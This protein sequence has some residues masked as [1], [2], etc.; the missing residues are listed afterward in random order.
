[1]TGRWSKAKGES[2]SMDAACDLCHMNFILK[3]AVG[4][5]TGLELECTDTE[6]KL[7]VTSV[8][9]WFKVQHSGVLIN[10]F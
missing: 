7:A 3:R 5:I 9:P 4:L 8:V 1:M 10:I 2:T 6:F